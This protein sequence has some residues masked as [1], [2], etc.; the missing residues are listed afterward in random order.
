MINIKKA[1]SI[2]ILFEVAEERDY[3]SIHQY[4]LGLQDLKIKVKALGIVR[5]KHLAMHFLPVLSFDFIYPN[6]LNWYGK[7]TSKPALEFYSADFDICINVGN[8]GCFPLKYIVARSVSSLK[9]GPYGENDKQL[10]D[11]MIHPGDGFNQ[12]R[13]LHQVHKYLSIL[14]PKEDA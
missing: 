11:V 6:N 4:L 12:N 2:G 10:Y 8:P 5:E 7:P 3:Q 9:V 13:F 14:N 1:S